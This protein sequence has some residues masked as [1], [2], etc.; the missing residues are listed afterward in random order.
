MPTHLFINRHLEEIKDEQKENVQRATLDPSP[1]GTKKMNTD[2]T[3]S[4]TISRGA[5]GVICRD[6]HG[7]FEGASAVVIEGITDPEILEAFACSEATNLHPRF[8]P[9]SSTG[10]ARI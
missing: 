7:V 5:V 3:M 4:P 1:N 9:H 8:L 6:D 2:A 10:G